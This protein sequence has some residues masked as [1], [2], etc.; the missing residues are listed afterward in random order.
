MSRHKSIENEINEIASEPYRSEEIQGRHYFGRPQCND[1]C[2]ADE[3]CTFSTF[4]NM[5][6]SDGL[7]SLIC[8]FYND[9][10]QVA[11]ITRFTQVFKKQYARAGKIHAIEN[12]LNV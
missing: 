2:L 4:T 7:Y 9:T 1:I 8:Y 10:L 5:P 11:S 6:P 3:Q 12:E